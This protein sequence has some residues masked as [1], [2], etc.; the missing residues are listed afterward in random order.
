[1][2]QMGLLIAIK[3]VN[4]PRYSTVLD[5]E[6]LCQGKRKLVWQGFW[7]RERPTERVLAFQGQKDEITAAV[8]AQLEAFRVFAANIRSD[9]RVLERLEAAIMAHVYEQPSPY[10][11]VPDR[12]MML[13]PRRPDKDEVEVINKADV[14]LHTLPAVMCI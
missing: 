10:C 14:V 5:A 7:M 4:R 2:L 3:R 13:A 9:G 8:E 11:D 6:A 12:G 1:M